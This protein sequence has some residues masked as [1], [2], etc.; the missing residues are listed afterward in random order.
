MYQPM[1]HTQAIYTTEERRQSPTLLPDAEVFYVPA[2]PKGEL[3]P[4]WYWQSCYPGC[5]P[6]SEPVGP[7]P[8]QC[9]AI[10]DA[11]LIEEGYL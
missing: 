6:D 7:F 4:G 9:A 10:T 3:E 8:T 1:M 5:L 11:Q 2:S